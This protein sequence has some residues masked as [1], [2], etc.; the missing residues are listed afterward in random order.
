MNRYTMY[1]FSVIPAKAGISLSSSARIERDSRL[2]RNDKTKSQW[3]IIFIAL[4]SLLFATACTTPTPPPSPAISFTQYPAINFN[5]AKIEV[6]EAYKSPFTAPNI[7]HLMPLS[8]ADAMHLWIKDR[9][10]S[11]G[12]EKLLQITIIDA[13]VTETKLPKTQG[14]KGLF[15]IDQDKK[16]DARLEVEMR[17]YGDGALS[18]ADASVSVTRSITIPE[19]ASVNSRK[20]AY[21]QMIHDLMETLNAKLDKNIHEYMNNYVKY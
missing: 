8:P 2:R 13:P 4:F 20:A 11:V 3:I 5:V 6:V 17:I 19:N 16:Y 21:T 15:T 10:H 14:I 9:I 1:D 7:E 12:N 18:E